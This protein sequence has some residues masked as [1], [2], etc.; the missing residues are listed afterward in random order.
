M[1]FC[2]SPVQGA[3]EFLYGLR[4][5]LKQRV[6]MLRPVPALQSDLGLR[7]LKVHELRFFL[8]QLVLISKHLLID[9]AQQLAFAV[10]AEELIPA[11][12]LQL[13]EQLCLVVVDAFLGGTLPVSASQH[14]LVAALLREAVNQATTFI[15]IASTAE[16][17]L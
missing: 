14:R 17:V 4:L 16:E 15:A 1:Q 2:P 10:I 6:Q 13:A 8:V 5:L 12:T 3:C 11:K 7:S 9:L